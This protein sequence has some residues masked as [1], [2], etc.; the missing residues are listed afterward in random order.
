[1]IV[2]IF[3]TNKE[4]KDMKMFV[5]GL[6]LRKRS[7]IIKKKSGYPT[8]ILIITIIFFINYVEIGK[9]KTINVM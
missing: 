8:D 4:L 9:R 5:P 1:M 7:K 2:I 6:Y 3:G